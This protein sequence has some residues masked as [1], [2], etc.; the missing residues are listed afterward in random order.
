MPADPLIVFSERTVAETPRGLTV[1][2]GRP[3]AGD[4]QARGELID[5][6]RLARAW[7]AGLLGGWDR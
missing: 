4:E 2:L 3:R 1:I 6:W 5:D 7:L